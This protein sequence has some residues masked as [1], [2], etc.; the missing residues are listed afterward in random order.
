MRELADQTTRTADQ[1]ERLAKLK[2]REATLKAIASGK[3]DAEKA[4]EEAYKK[5]FA[6]PNNPGE[7]L[8]GQ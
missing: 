3:T 8:P 2:E 6:G 1:E 5:L 4:E 7:A